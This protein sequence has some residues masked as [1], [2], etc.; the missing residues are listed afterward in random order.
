MPKERKPEA[1]ES[2]REGAG[3]QEAIGPRTGGAIKVAGCLAQRKSR[4]PLIRMLSSQ[5]AL[6]IGWALG[7]M[8]LH[9][10]LC[11]D[12]RLPPYGSLRESR[13]NVNFILVDA[14]SVTSLSS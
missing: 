3:A 8:P 2:G 10:D 11:S 5:C 4:C 7:R 13:E 14:S 1:Q 6:L 12:D 9:R